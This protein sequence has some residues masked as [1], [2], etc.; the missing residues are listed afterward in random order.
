MVANRPTV[1]EGL[2]SVGLRRRGFSREVLEALERAYLFVYRTGLNTTQALEKIRGDAAL[3]A[4]EEVR[5]LVDFI[6]SS[7]RGIIPAPRLR[8]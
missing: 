2:N 4:V 3:M 7:K 1:W 6:A 5:I 8:H